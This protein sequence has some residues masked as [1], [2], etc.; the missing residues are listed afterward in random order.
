MIPRYNIKRIRNRLEG[1][2]QWN[3]YTPQ[4]MTALDMEF[5]FPMTDIN[6]AGSEGWVDMLNDWAD[7]DYAVMRTKHGGKI[8]LYITIKKD[9]GTEL[10]HLDPESGTDMPDGSTRWYIEDVVAVR[11]RSGIEF[12]AKESN[13]FGDTMITV[14]HPGGG[15]LAQ[16]TIY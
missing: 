9:D 5:V 13:R 15:W 4:D 8:P 7:N 2:T 3:S 6:V 16:I 1:N 11:I 14:E 10:S 12:S